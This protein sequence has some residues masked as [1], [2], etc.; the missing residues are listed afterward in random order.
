MIRIKI[1]YLL[2]KGGLME[3]KLTL[4]LDN[5]IISKAKEYAKLNGLSLSRMVENYFSNLTNNNKINHSNEGK[6][7]ITDS[8]IGVVK[9]ENI[10]TDSL[11]NDYLM[12]KYINE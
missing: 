7:P 5:S 2:R 3:A 9:Y 1:V 8:L 12:E 11:K 4:S 6:T 10:S